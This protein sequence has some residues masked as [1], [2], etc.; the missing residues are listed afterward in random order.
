MQS[1]E[2]LPS[3]GFV[4]DPF[5][6]TNASDEPYLHQYFIA[7]PFFSSVLG[8]PSQPR[9]QLILA[10]RGGGKTAQRMMVE[11]HGRENQSY[12]AVVY[13]NF[14]K[15]LRG[16]RIF[17]N[18]D[19]HVLSCCQLVLVSLLIEL[20]EDES[21]QEKLSARDRSLIA[22]QVRS[23][24]SDL[25]AA[26]F[27]SVLFAICNWRDKVR[28]LA[29]KYGSTAKNFISNIVSIF[30]KKGLIWEDDG[31]NDDASPNYHLRR[32]AEIA[33]SVGFE[34]VYILVDRIDETTATNANAEAAWKLIEPLALDLSTLETPGLA[35][36]FF[37][38]D[39][40]EKNI[41][42]S[43]V[44]RDRIRVFKLNWSV[45][46]LKEMLSS[47]LRAFSRGAISSFN[48][49]CEE[50][51]GLDVHKLICY[52]GHGSPRDVI[53]ICGRI[54]DL[55]TRATLCDELIKPKT[56]WKGIADFSEE[57]SIE[58]FGEHVDQIRR[59]KRP[60]FTINFVASEIL[61][62]SSQ[63]ARQKILQWTASG[64][65]QKIDEIENEGGRPLH[66]YAVSDPRLALTVIGSDECERI[67]EKNLRVC[68]QCERLIAVA[69]EEEERIACWNCSSRHDVNTLNS[70]L[71]TCKI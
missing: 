3:R 31:Q 65:C 6:S 46:E 64:A 38:W 23:W 52:L 44:R 48:E 40:M 37:A 8:D 56:V 70:L 35:F 32:L 19:L 61:R 66:L 22:F 29:D 51:V 14:H 16:K 25:E 24:L 69:G 12:M 11:R 15:H 67:V 4:G 34:A 71:E 5:Q 41:Q 36:K 39:Q 45:A 30:N 50:D 57:R 9:S 13:D 58:L 59:V 47:R 10:P 42:D 62:I 28:M 33:N 60:H 7:P 17:T 43:G 26:G 49:L 1:Q 55:H 2:F 63:G 27:E 21:K 18:L 68:L 54:I 53:R 20:A